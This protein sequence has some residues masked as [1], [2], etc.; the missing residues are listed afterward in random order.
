MFLLFNL[1]SRFVIAFLPRS[2]HLLISWLQSPSSVILVLSVSHSVVSNS[3]QP[4]GLWPARLLCPWD[5]PDKNTGVDC[6]SLLQRIFL[7]QGSNSS[8]LH[9]RQILYCLRHRENKVC[10]CFH[11]FPHLFAGVKYLVEQQEKFWVYLC[12]HTHTHTHTQ[13]VSHSVMSNTLQ[14]HGLW[15]TRL[16]CPWKTPVKNPGVGCHPLFQGIFLTQGSNPALLHCRQILYH[17]SHKGSPYLFMH[18]P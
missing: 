1:M 7:I 3:L 4:H 12:T 18:I 17:L 9:C 6:H 14:P 15:P 10:Y 16:L 5:S 11:C 8:L 2:K 13:K